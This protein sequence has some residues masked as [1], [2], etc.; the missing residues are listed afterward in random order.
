MS[1]D[2]AITIS[3][4]GILFS[5]VSMIILAYTN[6]FLDISNLI[7]TLSDNHA[8][9][10]DEHTLQQIRLLKKRTGLIKAIKM[11]CILAL[12]VSIVSMLL[13]LYSSRWATKVTFSISLILLVASLLFAAIEIALSTNALN[14]S[15]P[16]RPDESKRMPV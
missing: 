11:L 5:T 12:L 15:I 4:P 6:R 1:T 9:K 16:R 10:P 13:V 3:T 8:A 2:I 14:Q 7:R